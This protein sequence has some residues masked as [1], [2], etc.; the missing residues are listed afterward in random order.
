M[1]PSVA[2]KLMS[3]ALGKSPANLILR[4]GDVLDVYTGEVL[5]GWSVA[6]SGERIAYVGPD[7]V[8]TIGPRTEIIDT[9]GRLVIPGFI[10]AH[11]HIFNFYGDVS[12]FVASA[13]LSGTTCVMTEATELFTS[14]GFEAIDE[15]TAFAAGQPLRIYFAA[16]STT[17]LCPSA[18]ARA[19]SPRYLNRLLRRPNIHGLGESYW[20]FVLRHE[21]RVL[22][23]MT[24]AARAGKTVEGHSAGASGLKLQAY[25][26]SGVND[27]HEPINAEEALE[28]ARLGIYVLL[29]RGDVRNEL[30]AMAALVG[31]GISLRRFCLVS[32]GVNPKHLKDAGYM[33]ATVQEAIDRGFNPVDAI[34]MATLNPAEYFGLDRDLGGIAPGHYADILVVPGPR[35]VKPEMVIFNGQLATRDGALVN[36]ARRHI[37]SE[38]VRHGVPLPR[39]FTPA[40]FAIRAPADG[41]INVRIIHQ[42]TPL[43]TREDVLEMVPVSGELKL[44]PSAGLLKA[45]VIDRAAWPGKYFTAFIRGWGLQKGAF[46][47][48][49][50]WDMVGITVIGADEGDMAFA[51]NRLRETQ[52]GAVVVAGGNILAEL[53]LPVNGYLCELPSSEVVAKLRE[54]QHALDGLGAP[55]ADPQLTAVTLSSCSIPYL[56]LCESGLMDIRNHRLVGLFPELS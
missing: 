4:G 19:L 45:A 10:D 39:A 49:A 20:S 53:S 15:L 46:A 36:P 40:D 34:R 23:Q 42:V 30:P 47:I 2:R 14:L 33:D 51:V 8:H 13:T 28:R 55:Y 3:V 37:Y 56:R 22:R 16:P 5:K 32:D 50:T 41:K 9:S 44:D 43:V 25:L 17:T 18:N 6:V 29:R 35:R 21:P 54:I 1:K 48:S 27:C 26:A 7:P 24:A 31:R 11:S 38:R 52:G 12:D